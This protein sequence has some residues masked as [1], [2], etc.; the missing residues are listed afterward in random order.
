MR[1]AT[2]LT[3][4]VFARLTVLARAGSTARSPRRPLWRCLCVCGNEVTVL[5]ASL[6]D[7]RTR[8]CGCLHRETAREAIAAARAVR[9][10]RR[11]HEPAGAAG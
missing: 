7:G 10:E 1:P 5:A 2:D 6:R 4:R 9:M 3:G 11:D 8:S